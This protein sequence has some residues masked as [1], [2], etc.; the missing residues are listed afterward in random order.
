MNAECRSLKGGS[1]VWGPASG[2]SGL[3]G[4][5]LPRGMVASLC[6]LLVAVSRRKNTKEHKTKDDNSL[7]NW[8]F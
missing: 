8:K 3:G 1:G 6:C 5:G 7:D 4:R 2:V